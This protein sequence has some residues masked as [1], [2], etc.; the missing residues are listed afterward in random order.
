MDVDLSPDQTAYCYVLRPDQTKTMFP[1]HEVCD[2][3]K[4]TNV[5][6]RNGIW[7]VVS[8]V[9]G[10]TQEIS[11]Q[12]NVQPNRKQFNSFGSM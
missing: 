3:P 8:G 7:N 10:K 9:K 4:H 2:F 11:Y 6:E 5:S 12:I 1:Q